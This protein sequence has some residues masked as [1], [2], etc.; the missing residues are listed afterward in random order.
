MDK[1]EVMVTRRLPAGGMELLG[2]SCR[3]RLWDEDRP[4]PEEWM[5][6]NAAG[7]DGIVCLL[8]DRIDEAMME[9]AGPGLKVISVMAAGYDGIDVEAA[10]QRGVLVGN[11]PGVLSE[12]TAD[13]T[14]ALILAVA[15]R[16]VDGDR[17]MR[18]G[19]FTGW[20]P[21]LLVGADFAG[22]RLGIVGMGRIGR[23]VARRGIGFG[24]EVVYHNRHRLAPEVEKSIPTH[25]VPLNELIASSDF[26]ALHCPLNKES[27][28]LLGANELA[29]MKPT[30]YLIN[31]ARG[32]VVDEDALVAALRDRRIAGAALDVYEHEPN[33]TP[34]L[35][36]LDNVVL[37]P[38]LGSAAVATRHRMAQMTVENLLAGMRGGVPPWCVNPEAKQA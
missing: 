17:M 37:A 33:L 30:A 5:R 34:G 12:A 21:T 1:F 32:P 29:S 27:Y 26:I 9:A 11:T 25:L 20:S 35:A 22:R 18:A 8:S 24:M 16:I 7:A 15:R 23:E 19:T 6:K 10:T 28:H 2:E 31:I 13:L 4:A 14:W 3:P 38:H 36:E